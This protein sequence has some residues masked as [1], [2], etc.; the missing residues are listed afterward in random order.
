MYVRII[1]MHVGIIYVLELSSRN[2]VYYPSS[3]YIIRLR[4][5]DYSIVYVAEIIYS[6]ES[7]VIYSHESYV[8]YSH[9][10]YV[11]LPLFAKFG[12]FFTQSGHQV[13][14]GKFLYR[15]NCVIV[16]E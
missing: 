5:P 9:E 16:I 4:P 13:N 12:G 11:I 3:C 6:H 2:G 15:C 14:T 10:S 1:K 7:Y 8:I